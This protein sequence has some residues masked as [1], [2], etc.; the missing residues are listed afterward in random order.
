[1]LDSESSILLMAEI[2]HH[3]GFIKTLQIMGINHISTGS[4]DF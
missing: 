4:P 3:L 1:M 2:L